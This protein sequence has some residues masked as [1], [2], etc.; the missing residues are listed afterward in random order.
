M[1]EV[2]KYYRKINETQR[3]FK[4]RCYACRDKEESLVTDKQEVLEK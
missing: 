4:P 1:N 2:Q 3:I